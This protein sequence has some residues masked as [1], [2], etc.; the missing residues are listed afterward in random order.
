MRSLNL[1]PVALLALVFSA[2]TTQTS[3]D[4]A[5]QGSS[6]TSIDVN[7][8]TKD[9][10]PKG[11]QG[12]NLRYCFSVMEGMTPVSE[13]APDCIVPYDSK[14]MMKKGEYVGAIKL[15]AKLDSSKHYTVSLVIGYAPNAKPIKPES[16]IIPTT[17]ALAPI[18]DS[19]SE[20]G[21]P[22]DIDLS[23]LFYHGVKSVTPADM[24]GLS[25]LQVSIE[26]NKFNS[27]SEQEGDEQNPDS[28]STGKELDI[29]V[30]PVFN[31]KNEGMPANG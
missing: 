17:I 31:E 12:E 28:I 2:C 21:T 5:K 26:L 10:L 9:K 23:N 24:K 13:G 25:K 8:P 3:N 20:T 30:V 22:A 14:D 27:N 6:L 7:L 29:E 1:I 11:L 4:G 18:A 15:D 16:S 19:I